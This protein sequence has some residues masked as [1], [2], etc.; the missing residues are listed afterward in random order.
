[1]DQLKLKPNDQIAISVFINEESIGAIVFHVIDEEALSCSLYFQSDVEVAAFREVLQMG[2]GAIDSAF[3]KQHLADL[4]RR[5]IEEINQDD[6][7]AGEE[8]P[9]PT[10]VHD[11]PF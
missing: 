6:T 7:S 3:M 2:D 1:M 10:D 4:I 11:I 5:R 8:A 9:S